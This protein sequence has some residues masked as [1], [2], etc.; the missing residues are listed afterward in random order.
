MPPKSIFRQPGAKH[1]QLVHRSQRDPRIHDPDASQHVLKPVERENQRKGK[2]RADLEAIFPDD[3]RRPNAGEAVEYGIYYDDTDYDYM[4]H[5]RPIGVQVDGVE[6]VLLEA[7]LPAKAK[8]KKQP[9]LSLV[10]IPADALP[11]AHELPR[12]YESQQAVPE[13]I[14]GFQPD[15]DPHLRQV[16]E[17]LEDEAFI[18]DDLSDDFFGELVKDGERGSEEDLEFEFDE[19]GIVET[20]EAEGQD[21]DTWEDR[22]AQFKKTRQTEAHYSDD[23]DESETGDTISGLPETRVI[24]GKKRRKG[25]SVASGY[26]MTSSSMYRNDALQLLD[27]RFDH[28]ITKNY[29]EDEDEEPEHEDAED[30]DEAPELITSREDFNSMVNEFLN[31][32]EVLGRKLKPKLEGETGADKLETIRR[33]LGQD[34][35]VRV[36]SADPEDDQDILVPKDIDEEKDRWDCETILSTY[37]NLENHPRLI[38]ARDSKHVPKIRLDP[39]TGLPIV[40]P[41][42][43]EAVIQPPEES[44]SGSDTE[45]EGIPGRKTVTRPRNETPE[46]KKARKAAIKAERQARREHKRVTK[47]QFHAEQQ[48]QSRTLG[49]REPRTKKL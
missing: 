1:F 37:S 3:D 30:S 15:M 16:L 32:F 27:E 47:E 46:A 20:G 39:K 49:K 42:T 25:S 38:R 17:A 29:H 26:S 14:A 5:L 13:S 33:A 28:M 11:S 31:D 34:E 9:G 10:D 6:S 4:Q 7:P 23:E 19:D 24:G 2:T 22:F 18:D 40:V 35:R 21:P 48:T 8:S 36:A 43:K 44:D 12:T 45:R 41:Q